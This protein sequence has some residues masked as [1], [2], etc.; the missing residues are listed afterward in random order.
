MES[1]TEKDNK[2]MHHN[3]TEAK[4]SP[5]CT[6][7]LNVI[8]NISGLSWIWRKTSDTATRKQAY[9]AACFGAQT[10]PLHHNLSTEGCPSNILMEPKIKG[11]HHI[12]QD[13]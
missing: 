5:T 9:H 3:A 10:V 4:M 1:F 12:F 11:S 8:L 7:Q 2:N 13:Y 6:L